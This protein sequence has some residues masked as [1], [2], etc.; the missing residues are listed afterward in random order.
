VPAAW[1]TFNVAPIAA[2]D[3][4]S[5]EGAVFDGRYVDFIPSMEEWDAL[6]GTWCATIPNRDSTPPRRGRCSTRCEPT[7][8]RK[9]SAEAL[10]TAAYFLPGGTFGA[11]Y[12][13]TADFAEP[14]SWS[15]FA[16][17]ANS[18]QRRHPDDR[19]D[20]RWSLSLFDSGKFDG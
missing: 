13:T 16:T 11:R 15:G 5:F 9:G 3:V 12:D 1:S 18:L 14:H 6:G 17:T 20:F 19:R 2:T 7:P 10:S 8:K 4:L